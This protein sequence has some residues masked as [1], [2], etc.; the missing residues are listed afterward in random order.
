[1]DIKQLREVPEKYKSQVFFDGDVLTASEM[2]NV[3]RGIDECMERVP[4]APDVDGRYFLSATVGDPD[5]EYV[6]TKSDP[7]TLYRDPYKDGNV[8]IGEDS[9][10]EPID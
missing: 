4:N 9:S 5:S 10:K 7:V 3:I 8:I 6:W 1:M 2:N